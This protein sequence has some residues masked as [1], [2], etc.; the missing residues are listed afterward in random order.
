MAEP[1]DSNDPGDETRRYGDYIDVPAA[2]ELFGGEAVTL[3]GSGEATRV[4][5]DGSSD[6][7]AGYVYGHAAAGDAVTVK[8]GGIGVASVAS[9]VGVGQTVGS[10]DASANAAVEAG[11]LS[12]AGDEYVVR[13]V[14]TKADP[15]DGTD[16][17]YAEVF[18][19]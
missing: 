9:D 6:I 3:N 11:D 13:Q 18:R 8:V 19:R 7:V 2:E 17:D 16:S 4:T 5:G 1:F 10:H 14:G 15:R 12:G